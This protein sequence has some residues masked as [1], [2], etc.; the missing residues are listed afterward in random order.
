MSIY[1]KKNNKLVIKCTLNNKSS[2]GLAICKNTVKQRKNKRINNGNIV[3]MMHTDIVNFCL[4]TIITRMYSSFKY[5]R[6]LTL[7][8]PITKFVP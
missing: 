5:S 4:L 3:Y 1:T 7:E 8:L 2:K 6:L